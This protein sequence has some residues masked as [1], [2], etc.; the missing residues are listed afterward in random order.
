MKQLSK[1]I[2]IL[3]LLVVIVATFFAFKYNLFQNPIILKKFVH[4]FGIFGPTMFMLLQIIQPIVP[5]IPG[6]VSDVAA[7][8]SFGPILGVLYASV[9]L[10]IGEI[11]LFLLVHKYGRKFV[12]AI[13][14]DKNMPR[15]ERLI[16]VGNKH[17]VWMLI[18]AFLMP[19]GPDDLA[20]LASGFTKISLKDYIKTII[21]LKP[22]SVGIHC[23]LLLD[24]F[25]MVK[26]K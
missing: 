18:I 19:F 1:I 11:I 9:G 14:S 3:G 10:V 17:T 2:F 21:L 22:I 7:F 24:V 12:L 25:K 26:I 6:G 8:L 20:C 4:H 13:T 16:D 23:Y 15:L 5:I